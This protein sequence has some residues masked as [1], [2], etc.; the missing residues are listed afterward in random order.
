M[1]KANQAHRVNSGTYGSVIISDRLATKH[2]NREYPGVFLREL[3]IN[4]YS[5]SMKCIVKMES[6]SIESMSITLERWDCSLWDL[7][8]HTPLT[9]EEKMS[10][11]KDVLTGLEELHS[12]GVVHADIKSSNI[13]VR[14]RTR[15]ALID[16]SLSGPVG[17][18]RTDRTTRGYREPNPS[19]GTSSDVYSLGVVMV[20]MFCGVTIATSPSYSTM[21]RIVRSMPRSPVRVVLANVFGK[22]EARMGV[23]D[24]LR[25]LFPEVHFSPSSMNYPERDLNEKGREGLSHAD[26]HSS[27][28]SFVRSL[29]SSV[30]SASSVEK[31]IEAI[32][33]SLYTSNCHSLDLCTISHHLTSVIE[34]GDVSKLFK[35]SCES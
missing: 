9:M 16:F 18:A 11:L 29:P 28:I 5:S 22:R 14:G 15:A 21:N 34:S 26:P 20:E 3:L 30:V 33:L 17:Y 7:L 13:M 31:A 2:F 23:R 1:Y 24:I 35:F 6:Y 25:L 4:K 8:L 12:H 27:L 19:S 10:I 32:A